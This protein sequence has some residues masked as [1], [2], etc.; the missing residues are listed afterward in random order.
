MD[1]K[2]QTCL[3]KFDNDKYIIV[4]ENYCDLDID[5]I[6]WNSIV[7]KNSDVIK[8]IQTKN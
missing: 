6:K 2:I 4:H 7:I 8:I 1:D 5:S 3:E